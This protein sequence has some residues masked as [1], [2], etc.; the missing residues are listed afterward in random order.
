M[1]CVCQL[2]VCRCCYDQQSQQ[3]TKKNHVI[4]TNDVSGGE[5]RLMQTFVLSINSFNSQRTWRIR[6]VR[7]I[8]LSCCWQIPWMVVRP[9]GVQAHTRSLKEQLIGK[10]TSCI[11][12]VV[13]KECYCLICI[14]QHF[15]DPKL[16][17]I[18]PIC[19]QKTSDL[20]VSASAAAG[21]RT[22]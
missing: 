17:L 22:M 10:C 7:S 3:Q 5:F 20:A 11:S 14:N 18:P 16:E 19:V 6:F 21:L 1:D 15:Y 9:N 8:R 2:W 12:S 13:L 4:E